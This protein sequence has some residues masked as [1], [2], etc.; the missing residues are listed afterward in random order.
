MIPI[1]FF[2]LRR[3]IVIVMQV[4]NYLL[5]GWIKN[6]ESRG[7]VALPLID[8]PEGT[9]NNIARDLEFV[10]DGSKKSVNVRFFASKFSL[11]DM[12]SSYIRSLFRKL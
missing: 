1:L 5:R 2:V 8:V 4:V 6:L 3:L 7:L 9:Q 12:I 10:R 11:W